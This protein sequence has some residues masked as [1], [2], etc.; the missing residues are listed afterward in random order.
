MRPHCII[1]WP[2]NLDV[3]TAASIGLDFSVVKDGRPL[4]E[5][6]SV[7][8]ARRIT[9]EGESRNDVVAILTQWQRPLLDPANPSAGTFLFRGGTTLL[10][11]R[12]FDSDPVRYAISRPVSSRPRQER[13]RRYE[14]ER[15]GYNNLYATVT[16]DNT[17]E[18]FGMLHRG[19]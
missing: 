2:T 5:V 7:R 3:A 15:G 14:Q 16:P 8:P 12:E 18:P 11:S 17:D 9:A 10:V 6:H 13:M 4:F 19:L 1:G